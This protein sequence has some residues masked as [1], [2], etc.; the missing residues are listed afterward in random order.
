M[1]RFITLTFV[2]AASLAAAQSLSSTCTSALASVAGN[3]DASACIA[4]SALISLV[5]NGEDTSI[6]TPV[7]TWLTDMCSAPSCSN[8]T[9]SAIV[10]NVTTGCGTELAALGYSTSQS[11]DILA[12]IQAAYPTVRNVL[13]LS[14]SGTNCITQTLQNIQTAVGGTLSVNKIVSLAANSTSVNIPSNVTCTNCVKQAYNVVQAS[15]PSLIGG[16]TSTLQT[17]CGASFTDGQQPAGITQTASTATAAKNNNG[18]YKQFALGATSMVV[19]S[20]AFALLA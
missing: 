13:C 8:D 2:S 11:S 10:A 1:A 15:F 14:D 20:A 6:V 18:A 4:P 7:N 3:A 16:E 12:T 17:Q 5:V 19:I 9:L